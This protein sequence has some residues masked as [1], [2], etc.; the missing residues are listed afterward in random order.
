MKFGIIGNGFVGSASQILHSEHIHTYI[1]DKD[2]EKCKPKNTS[3]EE[4][5]LCDIIFICLPTPMNIKTECSTILIENII[6]D[7]QRIGKNKSS[8]VVRSTVPPGTCDK[9]NCHFMPEFLT[10][11]NWKN[12]FYNIEHWIFGEPETE[13]NFESHILFKIRIKYLFDESFKNGFI[14]YNNYHFVKNKEAELLKYVRNTFLSTK[15]SFYNEIQEYCSKKNIKYDIIKQLV[16]LDTRFSSSHMDVPGP[17][18]KRGYGGTCFPKDANAL[19]YEMK[20]VGLNPILL[21][22]VITRNEEIDRPEKDWNQSYGRSV[23]NNIDEEKNINIVTGGAGFIGN[24][25]CRK[26]LEDNNNIVICVDNLMS[27]SEKNINDIILHQNFIFIKHDII[28]PLNLNINRI[29]FIYNLACP[30]SPPIYQKDPI[31]TSETCFIGTLNMLKLAK[32]YNAKLLQ[33]STSE[34]YGDPETS[35]Q[36]EIYNGNVN[37]IGIRSC[38]DEGKRISESLIMDYNRKY[39]VK[40]RIARIF[41]TFGPKMNPHDGRVISNFLRQS[42]NNIPITIYGSGKQTR[43]FCY[44]SDTVQGLLLLM[45][46]EISEPINIGNIYQYTILDTAQII[47]KITNSNSDIVYEDLPADDPK[48]RLPDLTRARNLLGYNPS[49]DFET[50]LKLMIKNYLI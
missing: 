6:K 24:Y 43:S 40:T 30:A 16:I 49:I 50:G 48:V 47:K 42:L 3:F 2:P 39:N 38:Y 9:L 10:E 27:G 11:N 23:L 14:K 36:S 28:D 15:V 31:H 17:D 19:R 25:L 13:S 20:N 18:G 22:A 41:N 46:S 7:I 12:D 1:Y 35:I 32:K 44:V 4:I 8:I 21:N 26:L 34:I 33:A 5:C 37:C 29:D 45:Q